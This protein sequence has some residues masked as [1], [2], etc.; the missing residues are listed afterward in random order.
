MP[1]DIAIDDRPLGTRYRIDEPDGTWWEVGWDRPLGTFYAQQYSPEPYD[2]FTHDNLL[3]WHGA[4]P[5]ELATIEALAA[6]LTVALPDDIAEELQRDAD[7]HPHT[8]DPPFLHVARALD[9][10]AASPPDA[11]LSGGRTTLPAEPLANALQRLRTDPYLAATDLTSLAR[12]LGI[13]PSLAQGVIDESIGELSVEQIAHVCEALR[14]SPYELW[15]QKLGREILDVYGPERWPRYIEPL[16]DGRDLA[17][18]D[19]FI[20]RRVEQQATEVVSI[21]HR[22]VPGSIAVDVTRYRQTAVLAVDEH[23]R[24]APV[25]DTLQPADPTSDYHFAFQRVGEVETVRVALTPDA[26][27]AGCPPGRDASPALVHIADDLERRAP[28]TDLFRFVDTATSSEQW[29]GRDT[30][31][32][33]WQNWDDPRRCYP[34]DPTDVLDDGPGELIQPLPLAPHGDLD[35]EPELDGVSLDF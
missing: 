12:G 6:R 2:P 25:A 35:P 27:A 3:A 23:G 31:F 8:V 9:E 32:D 34:G 24:A 14:C 29:L 10:P 21:A 13:D 16:D 28:G 33:E 7:A 15:G 19:S 18:S 11:S 22:H 4:R 5:S 30:P 17:R 26:F 20:R 1:D